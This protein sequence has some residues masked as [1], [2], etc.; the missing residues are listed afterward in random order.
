MTNFPFS[1]W[2]LLSHTYMSH[3]F[4]FLSSYFSTNVLNKLALPYF[5]YLLIFFF[6]NH[7]HKSNFNH[8]FDAQLPFLC[9]SWKIEVDTYFNL[10]M[11][12]SNLRI[13]S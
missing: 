3:C 12:H 1:V 5:K 9:K 13:I 7:N 8:K 11:K 6:G 4:S 10:H 2:L